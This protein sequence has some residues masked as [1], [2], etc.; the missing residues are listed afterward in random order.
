MLEMIREKPRDEFH[1]AEI[2]GVGAR[3]LER[4]GDAFLAVIRQHV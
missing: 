4:Y 3:K 1:F 2:A